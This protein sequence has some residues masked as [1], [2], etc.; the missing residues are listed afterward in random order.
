MSVL[1]RYIIVC[2]RAISQFKVMLLLL[3]TWFGITSSVFASQVDDQVDAR[4]FRCHSLLLTAD[5][6]NGI[7]LV[8]LGEFDP[9]AR[10]FHPWKNVVVPSDVVD[11]KR[12]PVMI[13]SFNW[14]RTYLRPS[15]VVLGK[16]IVPELVV[17]STLIN[18]VARKQYGYYHTTSKILFL[19]LDQDFEDVGR[20]L[21]V[22]E[23]PE[24]AEV[25]HVLKIRQI[26]TTDRL[27]VENDGGG[28]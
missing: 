20:Q 2:S 3:A 23:L 25:R 28:R 24:D 17:R 5:Y 19:F 9:T 6:G 16:D 11:M 4:V 10:T 21:E 27:A 13:S 15:Q 18:G 22:K 12:F 7:G 14:Y 1:S 8:T 26:L